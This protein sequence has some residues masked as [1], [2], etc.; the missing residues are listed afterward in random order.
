MTTSPA[1]PKVSRHTRR[2]RRRA[3]LA[4]ARQSATNALGRLMAGK[5]VRDDAE[6]A[7]H[8]TTG[9]P[10]RRRAQGPA[11]RMLPRPVVHG[12]ERPGSLTRT[13][14]L[15]GGRGAAV[16]M[17]DLARAGYPQLTVVPRVTR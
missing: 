8:V 1:A 16:A 2:R 11:G 9:R 4:A 10:E 5:Y 17:R 6:P 7:V 13:S 14:P 3:A 15:R 12:S